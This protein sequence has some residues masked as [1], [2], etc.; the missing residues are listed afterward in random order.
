LST[1]RAQHRLGE[2]AADD[3]RALQHRLVLCGETIDSRGRHRL[4]AGGQPGLVQRTTQSVGPRLSG[5]CAVLDQGADHLLD[6]EGIATGPLRQV[7]GQWGKGRV[8]TTQF[9]EHLGHR[10]GRQREQRDLPV[11]RVAHPPTQGEGLTDAQAAVGQTAINRSCGGR[12]FAMIRSTSAWVSTCG[13]V[14][15]IRGSRMEAPRPSACMAATHSLIIIGWTA[16]NCF[17]GQVCGACPM[18]A[19]SEGPRA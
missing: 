14:C 10:L 8:V 1:T 16:R 3:R 4:H 12:A 18:L 19:R 11:R 5:E 2:V 17:C 7:A 15:G 13:S 9:G 6:E